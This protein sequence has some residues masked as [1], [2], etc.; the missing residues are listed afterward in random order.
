M[1]MPGLGRATPAAPQQL[2]KGNQCQHPLGNFSVGLCGLGEVSGLT[3]WCETRAGGGKG[4]LDGPGLAAQ[5]RQCLLS[6]EKGPAC[7]DPNCHLG[8]AGGSTSSSCQLLGHHKHDF[9]GVC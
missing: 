2:W 8:E 6:Y 4:P 1:A 9:H 3:P 7:A 5:P